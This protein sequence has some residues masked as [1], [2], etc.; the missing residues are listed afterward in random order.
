[1]NRLGLAVCLGLAIVLNSGCGPKGPPQAPVAKVK[2][3]VNID[4]K[5]IP[6]GEIHFGMLGVP[7]KVSKITE[8]KYE[9]EAPVGD[10]KVEVF[11][12]KEEPNPRYPDNPFKIN[13]VPDKYSGPKTTLKASV[14]VGET[15]EFPFEITSK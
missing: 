12:Y 5:P 4:G 3:T 15:N 14:Q 8:G 10:N 6:T 13:T 9:G 2:G 11:I 7:P 1:M